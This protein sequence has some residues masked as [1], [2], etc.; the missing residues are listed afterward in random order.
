MGGFKL[1][2][3]LVKHFEKIDMLDMHAERQRIFLFLLCIHYT[4]YYYILFI[5][6]HMRLL[7]PICM[8]VIYSKYSFNTTIWKNLCHIH[9]CYRQKEKK[10]NLCKAH[11]S[12]T[13]SNCHRIWRKF[14]FFAKLLW[15][16]YASFNVV[17]RSRSRYFRLKNEIELMVAVIQNPGNIANV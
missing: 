8:C 12:S 7:L 1:L 14:N 5:T 3:T 16:L 9:L 15:Q 10:K 13:P 4:T 17:C 6:K 2:V 11:K